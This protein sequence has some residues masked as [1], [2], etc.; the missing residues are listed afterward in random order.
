MR[1][2][3]HDLARLLLMSRSLMSEQ[4][5]GSWEHMQDYDLSFERLADAA[6]AAAK[7]VCGKDWKGPDLRM[8][9]TTTEP[10]YDWPEGAPYDGEATYVHL[11]GTG[12]RLSRLRGRSGGA[13]YG[14]VRVQLGEGGQAAPDGRAAGVPGVPPRSAARCRP[15]PRRRV[16]TA[17]AAG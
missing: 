15:S 16:T 6:D 4:K 3:H 8:R 5:P 11:E 13:L 12:L 14:A 9:C 2:H 7:I 17:V 1:V 10:V